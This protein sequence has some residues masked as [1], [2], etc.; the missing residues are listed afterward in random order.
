MH[1]CLDVLVAR[2]WMTLRCFLYAGLTDFVVTSIYMYVFPFF[3]PKT[4][5]LSETDLATFLL[6]YRC[7]LDGTPDMRPTG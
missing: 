1:S 6:L 2:L 7:Q 3:C 4:G 5:S